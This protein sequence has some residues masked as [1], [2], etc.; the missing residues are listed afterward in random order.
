MFRTRYWDLLRSVTL[1]TLGLQNI[2]AF[3]QIGVAGSPRYPW[4]KIPFSAS[5]VFQ[6]CRSWQVGMVVDPV[7]LDQVWRDN[8]HGAVFGGRGLVELRQFPADGRGLF[9]KVKVKPGV[10]QIQISLRSGNAITH[11]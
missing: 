2:H 4:L 11:Y 6:L 1:I 8:S 5:H 3:T 10:Y 7:D 9:Q